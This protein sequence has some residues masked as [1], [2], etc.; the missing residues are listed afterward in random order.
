M[1]SKCGA[2]V[3][4]KSS[5]SLGY[6]LP[7]RTV[8]GAALRANAALLQDEAHNLRER[9]P[10]PKIWYI[11]VLAS[12]ASPKNYVCAILLTLEN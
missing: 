12:M 9:S 3:F 1:A 8:T 10:A 7:P 2:L 11:N 6:K 5:Q 4:R